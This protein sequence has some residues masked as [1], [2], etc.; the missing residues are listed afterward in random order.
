MDGIF[1]NWPHTIE[2]TSWHALQRAGRKEK[3]QTVRHSFRII[4]D[5]FL[6]EAQRFKAESTYEIQLMYLQSFC[7]FV[8]GRRAVD[9]KVHHVY[10]PGS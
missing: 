6:D 4:A 8:G 2:V 1:S 3:A 7:N 9:L 5:L 10:I